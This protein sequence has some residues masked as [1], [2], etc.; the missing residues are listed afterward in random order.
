MTTDHK[1]AIINAQ[2]QIK[3]YVQPWFWVFSGDGHDASVDT[4]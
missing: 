2:I 1:E 3:L 4:W